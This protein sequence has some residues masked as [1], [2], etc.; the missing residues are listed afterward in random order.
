MT[1]HDPLVR[2]EVAALALGVCLK[3]IRVYLIQ[4]KLPPLHRTPSKIRAWPLSVLRAHDPRL[5]RRCAAILTTLDSFPLK[6]AA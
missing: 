6:K 5:A 2:T 1:A 4:G 3:T